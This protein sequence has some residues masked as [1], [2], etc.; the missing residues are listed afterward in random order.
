MNPL[1]QPF[2]KLKKLIKDQFTQGVTPHALA[3]TC[4]FALC[5]GLFPILGTT[6]TLCFLFALAFRLNQ[7]LIQAL[8]YL[9]YPLQIIFIAIFVYA[10]EWLTN[11]AHVSINPK[12]MLELFSSDWRAFMNQ[13]AMAG[14]RAVLAWALFAPL[15]GALIY[16]VTKPIFTRIKNR[17]K[18]NPLSS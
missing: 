16:F 6:T 2:H 15:A 10:G 5:L 17:Q 7:P 9:L 18:A 13:Y 11:A 8:N 14:A 4:S 3:L 1:T 12:K